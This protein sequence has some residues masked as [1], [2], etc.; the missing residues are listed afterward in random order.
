MN[1]N[2]IKNRIKRQII[3]IFFNIKF[4]L[5]NIIYIKIILSNRLLAFTLV[6]YVKLVR[7]IAN[8]GLGELY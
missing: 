4:S 8:N 2:E 7:Y 6:G 3:I 5:K 1:K